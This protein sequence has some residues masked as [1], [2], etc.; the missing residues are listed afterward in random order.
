MSN[1][2]CSSRECWCFCYSVSEYLCTANIDSRSTSTA[3]AGLLC[4]YTVSSD[5][6]MH[7]TI[8]R[9]SYIQSQPLNLFPAAWTVASKD[10]SLVLCK[11][12]FHGCGTTIYVNRTTVSLYRSEVELVIESPEYNYSFW[13]LQHAR[14][15]SYPCKFMC[16]VEI[17]SRCRL[18]ISMDS[19]ADGTR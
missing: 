11:F 2:V 3:T 18:R 4:F 9:M 5:I 19:G 14:S 1:R 13:C 10:P 17:C 8:P 6:G 15:S 16:K 7:C 12:Q